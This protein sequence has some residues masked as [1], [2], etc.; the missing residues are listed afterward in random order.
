MALL[1]QDRGSQV[2]PSLLC[3]LHLTVNK[4]QAQEMGVPLLFLPPLLLTPIQDPP[5]DPRAP[6]QGLDTG[7][8]SKQAPFLG[9]L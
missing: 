6:F 4:T 2:A 5:G 7:I 9:L 1:G 3:I 8:S